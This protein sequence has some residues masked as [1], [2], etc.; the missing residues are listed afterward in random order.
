MKKFYIIT[1]IVLI[2]A[3]TGVGVYAAASNSAKEG[4]DMNPASDAR[5][6]D[7]TEEPT[8]QE[9]LSEYDAQ[10]IK[11][12]SEEKVYLEAVVTRGDYT[13]PRY[14]FGP[15]G[16]YHMYQAIKADDVRLYEFC[17]NETD[18]IEKYA[19]TE[20]KKVLSTLSTGEGKAAFEYRKE[21][22]RVLGILP[23]SARTLTFEDVEKVFAELRAMEAEG[24][25]ITEFVAAEK[26]DAIAGSADRINQR[27][28]GCFMEYFLND[29]GTERVL[30]GAGGT[31]YINEN[32]HVYISYDGTV[33]EY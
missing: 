19:T 33:S 28:C 3:V 2:L 29:D 30:A 23:E 4:A 16:Y 22:L 10:I 12:M 1:A 31:G 24:K 15:E 32:E 21:K 25:K 27:N 13:L 11:E 14:Y 8:K 20:Q 17:K 7:A 6:E 26:L 5:G 9:E 18:Y